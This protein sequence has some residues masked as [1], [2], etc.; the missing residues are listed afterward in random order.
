MA[1]ALLQHPVLCFAS[2]AAAV[3][4]TRVEVLKLVLDYLSAEPK[5]QDQSEYWRMH[6]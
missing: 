3:L 2:L 4:L 6:Q 1:S 5:Q